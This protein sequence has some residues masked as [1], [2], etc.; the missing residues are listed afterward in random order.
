VKRYLRPVWMSIPI[1]IRPRG[2]RRVT[3]PGIPAQSSVR[4]AQPA[5]PVAP[6]FPA[7]QVAPVRRFR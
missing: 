1:V 2:S 7:R 5:G 4:A 3:R 6:V